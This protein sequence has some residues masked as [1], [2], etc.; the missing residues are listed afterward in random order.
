VQ[1]HRELAS[2]RPDA[3]R[4]DLGMSPSNLG[5]RLGE[6][7]RREAALSAAEEALTIRLVLASQRPD[8]S[9]P[10]VAESLAVQ[11]SA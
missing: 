2:R 11:A 5:N 3:F 8:A 10:E 6:V 4:P 9:L 1:L 7:C